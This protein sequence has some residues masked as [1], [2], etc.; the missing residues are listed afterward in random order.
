MNALFIDFLVLGL[1]VLIVLKISFY[2]SSKSFNKDYLSLQTSTMLKGLFALVVVYHHM[3]LGI[4][5]GLLLRPFA[6]VGALAVSV[7]FFFSGYG[8]QKKYIVDETYSH[9]F[10]LRRLPTVLI[11]YIIVNFIFWL[12]RGANGTFYSLKYILRSLV[13]GSPFVDASWYIICILLFYVVFYF[14]MRICKRHYI[15]MIVGACL[16]N[17]IWI[18]CCYRLSYGN[19]WFDASHLLIVGMIWA[20]WEDKITEFLQKHYIVI[21]S[22][23][24]VA[25]LLLIYIKFSLDGILSGITEGIIIMITASHFV[26][27]VNLLGLKFHIGNRILNYLGTISFEIYLIHYLFIAELKKYI[28]SEFLFCASVLICSIISAHLLHKFFGFILS[29]YKAMLIRSK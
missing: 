28:S 2:K 14:L 8:L 12:W 29:K 26:L 16:Y 3:S 21:T 7:F 9:Q 1:A 18:I 13:N 10:L 27:I 5:S 17:L 15:W 22:V 25:F 19:W 23:A 4:T 20:T 24:S 11:P 6:F